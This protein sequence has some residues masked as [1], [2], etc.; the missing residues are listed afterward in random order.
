[1]LYWSP[2]S[3]QNIYM[4]ILAKISD[5]C[6]FLLLFNRVCTQAGYSNMCFYFPPRQWYC[7]CFLLP[8]QLQC[9]LIVLNA[10]ICKFIPDNPVCTALTNISLFFSDKQINKQKHCF[11]W[12][13]LPFLFEA[14]V[15]AIY[16][17]YDSYHS[18]I[19][20]D[21]EKLLK[22]EAF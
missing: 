12:L 19:M 1:M 22:F 21:T 20:I 9:G 13:Q 17:L 10:H 7:W 18:R 15:T 6:N 14:I 16:C 11:T 3:K 4:L 5:F 2:V 8:V